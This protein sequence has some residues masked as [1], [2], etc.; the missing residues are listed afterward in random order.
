MVANGGKEQLQLSGNCLCLIGNIRKNDAQGR[1][2][3]NA[4][5]TSFFHAPS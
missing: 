5:V 2:K 4:A 3:D 1:S